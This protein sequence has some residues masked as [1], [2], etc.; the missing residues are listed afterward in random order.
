MARRLR[1]ASAVTEPGM[2]R[3]PSDEQREERCV[4]PLLGGVLVWAVQANDQGCSLILSGFT[5]FYGIMVF[6]LFSAYD[7]AR[8]PHS[9]RRPCHG[10][11]GRTKHLSFLHIEIPAK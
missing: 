6:A 8:G 1:T 5:V 7:L 2:D 4:N 9:R 3:A 11:Q 10:R